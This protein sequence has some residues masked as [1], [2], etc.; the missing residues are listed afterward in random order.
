MMKI[1]FA[2]LLLLI[3]KSA[4]SQT[5]AIDSIRKRLL[6]NSVPDTQRVLLLVDLAYM[7]AIFS[8]DSAILYE[9]QGMNLARKIGYEKGEVYC[10]WSLGEIMWLTGA[11]SEANE[12]F[13]QALK[14][15]KLMNDYRAQMQ[16]Y[17]DLS[18]NSNDYG[19]YEEGLKYC[20]KAIELVK[21]VEPSTYQLGVSYLAA[22]A[23]Y[24][25][26]NISDSALYYLHQVNL[27][28]AYSGYNGFKFLMIGR[29][30]AKMG[31]D[32]LALKYYKLSMQTLWKTPNHKDM[33]AVYNSLAK[34]YKKRGKIDSC[35]YYAKKGF[36]IAQNASFKKGLFET[37]LFLSEIYEKKN[38]GLS[39]SYFKTAMAAKDSMFN[40]QK[41]TKFLNSQ[42]NEQM[43]VQ[44]EEANKVSNRNKI[45]TYTLLAILG[46]M[47]LFAIYY[48]RRQKFS[49]IRRIRNKIA[50]D[51]HDD[52]GATLSSI[53][54]MSELVNQQV[55]N[56]VP[57]ASSTLEKIG[58]SSRNM[59]ES[60]NDMVW[61]I[62]PQNDSFENIFK[63]MRT[64]AS[65]IL[66][67]KD[68][69]FHFDFDKNLIQLRLKMDMRRN[70]YLIFKEAVNNIAKY[71]G[72]ANAFVV[73]WNRDANLKMTIR[74]DGN[75]FQM[76]TVKGGNG[77]LNMQ[78]RAEVMK[79][80][81]KLES[82]P[83]KGTTIELEFKNE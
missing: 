1:L 79:A 62:N 47:I 38:A 58:S 33:V 57:Q 80:L 6:L 3:A 76:N 26:M 32:E 35:I 7:M 5:P 14:Y 46:G 59:I 55:K 10:K 54:I 29:T 63:R 20:F 48:N 31:N 61:A 13:L 22:G 27:P 67:A 44:E 49:D 60:V 53:S 56:Q 8:P 69:A 18:A 39:L 77:L 82:V 41:T 73:V 68:I 23:I 74:D 24:Q 21:S 64:F 40:L 16:V 36:D 71:S 52:L 25:E 65:E 43:R 19:N 28:D 81:F 4:C 34:L 11:Y 30:Y 37:S 42:F 9:Q 75:G 78:K 15:V 12:L 72:A 70:F 2:I 45:R 51:L 66:S 17:R 50:S 83:G